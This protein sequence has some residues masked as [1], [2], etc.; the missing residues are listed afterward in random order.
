MTRIISALVVAALLIG[1]LPATALATNVV[2]TINNGG[3]N[4]SDS[5]GGSYPGSDNPDGAT[6]SYSVDNAWHDATEYEWCQPSFDWFKDRYIRWS[7]TTVNN[8]LKPNRNTRTLQVEQDVLPADSY[9][10]PNGGRDSNLPWTHFY[11]ADIFQQTKDGYEDVAFGIYDPG[12]IV[13]GTNY[14]AYLQWEQEAD[15]GFLDNSPLLNYVDTKI[16]WGDKAYGL[17]NYDIIGRWKK[18]V[19]NNK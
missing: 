8:V 12:T 9:N 11:V 1:L 13:A 19:A 16:T 14:Y 7:S 4:G 2:C 10:W 17:K 3:V 18:K 5:I 15:G 6:G